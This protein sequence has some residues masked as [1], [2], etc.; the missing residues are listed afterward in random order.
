[1][2]WTKCLTT[3][4]RI[5]STEWALGEAIRK[6]KA[7]V[8]RKFHLFDHHECSVCGDAIRREVIWR[9]YTGQNYKYVCAK[10]A[11]TWEEAYDKAR[12]PNNKGVSYSDSY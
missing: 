12:D 8:D 3:M 7:L 1:M 10:D 11:R 4:T 6:K 2:L 9:V 5:K